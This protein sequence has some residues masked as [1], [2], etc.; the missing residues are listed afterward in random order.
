MTGPYS[1]SVVVPVYNE[2]DVVEEFHARLTAVLEKLTAHWEIVYVNDGSADTA[3]ERIWRLKSHDPRIAIV[4]L[5][6]NFGKE[7]AVTAGID[8]A[9]GDAVA[10]IDADLQDPPELIP[11]LVDVWR[12]R[13]VDM[14]YAQRTSRRGETWLKLTSARLFYKLMKRVGDT[15]M[16]LNTGE[17]RLMSRRVVEGVKT[18]RERHRFMKGIFAW[19][20]FSQAA[21]PYQRDARFAGS[22]KWNYWK[23][24]NFA[25]EGITSAT[26]AP[27]RASIYFGSLIAVAAFMFAIWIIV[28]TIAFGDPVQGWPSMMVIVL[29][30]GGVQL[31]VLGIIGEY[32]GRLFNETKGRPLYLLNS[33]EA[34]ELMSMTANEVASP[35]SATIV[36]A[37]RRQVS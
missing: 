31:M 32:L 13:G 24:W 14:V 23:L 16:P 7:I 17:F 30:L 6:R 29:F 1:L 22:S 20:G 26:I 15:P 28:K 4:D 25:I 27:L 3:L 11:A 2:E 35:S 34:S 5:S 10:L 8:H 33:M 37:A 18:L 12:D 21:V 36:P 9:V 19:V